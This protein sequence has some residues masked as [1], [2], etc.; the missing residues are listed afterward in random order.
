[1]DALKSAPNA[2]NVNPNVSSSSLA[3]EL[4]VQGLFPAVMPNG[5]WNIFAPCQPE[6]LVTPPETE[7]PE[8][9]LPPA[10][11]LPS[12]LLPPL[13]QGERGEEGRSALRSVKSDRISAEERAT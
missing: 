11:P 8:T 5:I 3:I 6:P 13:P 7:V 12:S 4:R 1:M 9:P 10:R 2:H